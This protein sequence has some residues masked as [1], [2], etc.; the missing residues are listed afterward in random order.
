MTEQEEEKVEELPPAMQQVMEAFRTINE[1]VKNLSDVVNQHSE[2]IK[3][4]AQEVV[5]L[6]E[7]PSSPVAQA[8]GN[9]GQ[10]MGSLLDFG[11]LL[12]G[13]NQPNPFM[14]MFQN[15][16]SNIMTQQS[17]LMQSSSNLNNS[18]AQAVTD[19]FG[20]KVAKTV[21]DKMGKVMMSE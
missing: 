18:I 2:A 9:E 20:Q 15:Y 6:K 1:N 12:V 21:S 5:S 13:R 7:H 19:M 14:D 11:K 16:M 17:Q 3:M 8:D 10:L 4:I